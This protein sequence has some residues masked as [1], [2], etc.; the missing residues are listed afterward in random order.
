MTLAMD[1]PYLT[2]DFI[3][4]VED[5]TTYGLAESLGI[6]TVD[7]DDYN[8]E[9]HMFVKWELDAVA[10]DW[11][12]KHMSP[13]VKRVKG[14]IYWTASKFDLSNS[15]E[16]VLNTIGAQDQ[17]VYFVGTIDINSDE[18]WKGKP[19][20]IEVEFEMENGG[21]CYPTEVYVD[22]VKMTI[23]IS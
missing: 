10:K 4:R 18:E 1:K 23:T 2:L 6:S 21:T 20:K 16:K 15:E 11:G 13:I 14:S 7:I 19:W 17:D 5:V 22:F 3:T 12:I 8:R 9:N